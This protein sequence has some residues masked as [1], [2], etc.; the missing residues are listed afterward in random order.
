MG[1]YKILPSSLQKYSRILS[2]EKS[3]CDLRH[4][5]SDMKERAMK[6]RN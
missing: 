5:G 6:G 1:P 2:P 4:C 3:E